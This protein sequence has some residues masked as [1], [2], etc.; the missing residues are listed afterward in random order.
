MSRTAPTVLHAASRTR[1]ASGLALLAAAGLTSCNGGSPVD[2]DAAYRHAASI[3]A[4]GPRTPGSAGH[5]KVVDYL[6][7]QL[8]ALGLPAH[9]QTSEVELTVYDKQKTIPL[10]NIWTEIPG[11]DPENG[12]ILL[13]GAHYDSKITAD[14]P[15]HQPQPGQPPQE[16]NFEFVAA[17]D[18]AAS[19]GLLLELARALQARD[20][21]PNVWIVWFDGEESIEFDWVDEEA[22]LGS[23]AFAKAMA[24]DQKRFPQ[25]LA[26]RMKTMVL[27]DLLGDHNLKIDRDTRSN[28]QL[29]DLFE[30]AAQEIGFDQMYLYESPMTDDHVPFRNY[31]V[32]VI[33]LIDFRHRYENDGKH[34][35]LKDRAPPPEDGVY[36]RWWHTPNDTMDNVSARSLG[37]VGDLIWAALPR[38]EAQFYGGE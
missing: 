27:L 22:L 14:H 33:D 17:L 6:K 30:E 29:L 25:G 4:C 7:Q 36:T 31:G 1:L 9:E 21:V 35:T 16:R 24:K 37:V 18:S 13:F 10:R 5:S 28:A 23:T 3:V 15:P 11:Q 34:P 12:P 19:C 32:P 26:A 38:I 8:E 2:S 20:T